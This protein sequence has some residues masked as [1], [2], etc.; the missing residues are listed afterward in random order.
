MTTDESFRRRKELN[1]RNEGFFKKKL[2]I[3]SRQNGNKLCREY[4][5]SQIIVPSGIVAFLTITTIPLRI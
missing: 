1:V 3:K 4:K 2:V 5:K